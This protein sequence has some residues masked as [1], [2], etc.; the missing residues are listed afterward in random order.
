M[1]RDPPPR[2]LLVDANV[3]IDYADADRSILT[4]VARHIAALHV[5]EPVL[6]EVESLD[7]T[8]CERLGLTVIDVPLEQ[9]AEAQAGV[10]A[11]SLEDR[12]CL[13]VAS[14]GGFTC[15]TNDKT[16][17]RQCA[18]AGVPTLWGLELMA[19]LVALRQLTP[20]VARAV[21]R[22]IHIAN[23]HHITREILRRFDEKL[24][25]ITR[26]LGGRNP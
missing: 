18:T 17:R 2:I 21:A 1:R 26:R 6:A 9:L 14:G 8:E 5:P 16:L 11:L 15:V 25:S 24:A 12:V 3:L 23:P 22:T 13:I 20:D 7:R 10:G 19:E 4:L